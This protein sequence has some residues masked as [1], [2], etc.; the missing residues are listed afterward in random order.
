MEFNKIHLQMIIDKTFHYDN[1]QIKS[2]TDVV[3]L[4]NE[5]ENIDKL[6][7]ETIFLICLDSSNNIISYSEIAKGGNNLC[8][9]DLRALFKRV[10]L[11]NATKFIL[12][13]NHPSGNTKPSAADLASTVE[14]Q[15]SALLMRITFLDHII[16]GS[17]NNFC[18]CMS[19]L[20]DKEKN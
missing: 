19:V 8:G 15:D 5:I 11:C 17:N 6:A 14:L 3:N 16:L 9:F 7:E 4:I 12:V 13:H 10:L 2:T 18:S 20:K 1:K